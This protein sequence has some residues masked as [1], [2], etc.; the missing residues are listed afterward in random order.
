MI[1]EICLVNQFKECEFEITDRDQLDVEYSL[2]PQWQNQQI[3]WKE[4]VNR[5][6]FSP[7]A[8]YNQRTK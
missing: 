7:S 3:S 5:L 2:N 6:I 4:K 8:F 1:L